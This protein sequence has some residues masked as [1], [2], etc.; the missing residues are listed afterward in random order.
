M[1]FAF[2][3]A[4][5]GDLADPLTIVR[6]AEATEAA[7]WDGFSTWDTLGLAQGTVAADP[8]VALAGAA[9][10]T[11]RIALLASVIV[12]PRRR[13]QLVAQAAATLDRL[14]GGRLILG[15]G[16]GGDQPDFEAFDEDWTSS[17][18]VARMDEAVRIVDA[19]LRGE[20]VSR[21]GPDYPV[22]GVGH[23]AAAGAAAA[24]A[25]LDGRAPPRRH[26]PRRPLG[27]LDRREHRRRPAVARDAAV[28][29]GRAG[30]AGARDPA[31]GG[32]RRPVRRRRVRHR[33]PRRVHAGRLRGRG[34]TWWLESVTPLRGSVADILAIANAGPPR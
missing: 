20:T 29:A 31:R 23:R 30:R 32:A 5:L 16:A 12:L 6:L 34:A 3:V 15:V 7:G 17:V 25:D 9:A 13:P 14:S 33:G 8:F 11:E 26:P 1:K 27:R 22:H 2:D 18:R 19:F 24:A 4:P 10:A 28:G 21:P